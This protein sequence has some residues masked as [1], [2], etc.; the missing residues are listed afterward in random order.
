MHHYYAYLLI[1]CDKVSPDK[2]PPPSPKRSLHV[3]FLGLNLF[4]LLFHISL[5]FNAIPIIINDRIAMHTQAHTLQ[6]MLNAECFISTCNYYIYFRFIHL[7]S[8]FR[9]REINAAGAVACESASLLR[10]LARVNI[11]INSIV[12]HRCISLRSSILNP[13]MV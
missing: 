1:K 6:K 2:N 10:V 4:F 11:V 9:C 12:R 3:L 8:H 13:I 7:Y 5:A